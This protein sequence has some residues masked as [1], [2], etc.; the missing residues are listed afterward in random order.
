VLSIAHALETYKTLTG[1][2]IE[3]VLEGRV[4][5]TVDGTV[6]ADTT[7]TAQLE[8]YHCAAAGAHRG[9]TSVKL[10]LPAGGHPSLRKEH[11]ASEVA[12]ATPHPPL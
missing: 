1:D 11:P 5:L 12:A 6:Y 10:A 2:D 8:E 9:H 4:G 3:A 7:F